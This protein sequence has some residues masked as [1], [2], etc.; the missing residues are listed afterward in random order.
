VVVLSVQSRVGNALYERLLISHYF[1]GAFVLL[2]VLVA[3]RLRVANST[4]TIR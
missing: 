4:V 1:M 2:C 3:E